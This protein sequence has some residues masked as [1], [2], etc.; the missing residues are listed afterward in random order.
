M[1]MPVVKVMPPSCSMIH[2]SAFRG[3][4]HTLNHISTSIGLY[5]DI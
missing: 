3:N 1:L 5:K 4:R 2:C